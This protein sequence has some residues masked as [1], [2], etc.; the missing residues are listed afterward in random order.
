MR[1]LTILL[2][3][4]IGIHQYYLPKINSILFIEVLGLVIFWFLGKPI[5][6]EYFRSQ[7]RKKYLKGVQKRY[8]SKN[9]TKDWRGRTETEVHVTKEDLFDTLK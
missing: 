4:L 2:L 1:Y 7:E 5:Y 3:A 8:L 6:K 9:E